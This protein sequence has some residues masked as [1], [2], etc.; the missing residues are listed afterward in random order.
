[1]DYGDLFFDGADGALRAKAERVMQSPEAHRMRCRD[2]AQHYQQHFSFFNF[3]KYLEGVSATIRPCAGI[4]GFAG[5]DACSRPFGRP[6]LWISFG[7]LP[8]LLPTVVLVPVQTDG[9]WG[10]SLN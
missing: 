4:A 7:S 6:A 8:P 2:F 3:L 5:Q 9:L 10:K 1:G